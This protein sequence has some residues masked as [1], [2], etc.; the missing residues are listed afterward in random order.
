MLDLVDKDFKTSII[1]IFKEL[2]QSI[3]L[4]IKG[5]CNDNDSSNREDQWKDRNYIYI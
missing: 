5:K 4:K 2:K 3:F 1:N